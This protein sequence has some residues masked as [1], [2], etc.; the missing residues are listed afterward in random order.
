VDDVDD[1]LSSER[2]GEQLTGIY[3]KVNEI[4]EPAG[5]VIDVQSIQRITIPGPILEGII[6]GDFQSFFDGLESSL[7]IPDPSLLNGFYAQGIGGPNGIVPFRSRLFFVT[8]Q[9]TVLHE[10]VTAH[11]IGHIL[12]LHHTLEDDGRLM[13]PGTNGKSLTDPEIAV[14]RYVATGMLNR[15]R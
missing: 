8:D 2:T 10:R 1:R 15:M 13:F 14:A 5:I 9:P 11:E 3:E 4:W 6:S 12:G 7:L